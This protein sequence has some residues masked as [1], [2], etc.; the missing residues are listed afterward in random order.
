MSDVA[1]SGS[2]PDAAA[3]AWT[4]LATSAV[5][6]TLPR[7]GHLRLTGDDRLPFL[8]GQAAADVT[9]TPVGHAVRTVFLNLKGHAWSEARV[10]R[11]ADDLHL[12]V[13]DGAAEAVAAHL[14]RHVVFDA[15]EVHELG[16][17]LTTVTVQ[18]PAAAAVVRR[19]FGAEAPAP[20]RFELVPFAGAEVLLADAPRSEPGGTDVHLLARDAAAVRAAL[21]EAGAAPGDVG[22]LE[23]SR[24]R[25][26]RPRAGT[27]AGEGVLPQEAALDDAISTRKGCYLGQE[28]M[29]RI[30]ARGRVRRG[31]AR[32]TFD[33]LPNERPLVNGAGRTVGRLGTVVRDPESGPSA[34]AVV[35]RDVRADDLR[36][37]DARVRTLAFTADAAAEAPA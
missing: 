18:G 4:A 22:T 20:G 15:V 31:L 28:I 37:G 33:R 30:E 9:G 14:R 7:V 17:V 19:A 5:V 35:R 36:C 11:R 6:V 27:E 10:H 16:A 34:L 12:A 21:E 23:V 13:E 3:P 2:P 29:A 1:P 24:V 26:G 8:H 32:L 25:A